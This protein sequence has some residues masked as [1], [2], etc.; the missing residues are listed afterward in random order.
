MIFSVGTVGNCGCTC[1]AKGWLEVC[2][3]RAYKMT[4]ESPTLLMTCSN[5]WN[6]GWNNGW[7]NGNTE[8]VNN[9]TEI[10]NN[11]YISTCVLLNM[12]EVNATTVLCVHAFHTWSHY[13]PCL[14]VNILP[15]V[16]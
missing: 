7:N 10:V 12:R 1:S 15:S 16:Q 4:S 8:I 13:A 14:M 11:T 3:W 2:R 6:D 9:N 5:G